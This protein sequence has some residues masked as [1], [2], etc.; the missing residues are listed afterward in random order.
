MNII[1]TIIWFIYFFGYLLVVYPVQL[2]GINALK[3]GD[4]KKSDALAKKYVNPWIRGLFKIANVKVEV[5]GKENIPTD[6]ACVIVC[7]HRGQ[8]DIAV[9][10]TEITPNPP[11]LLSKI[12]V[13]KIPF[14]RQWMRMLHCVFVDRKDVKKSVEALSE[15]A[16]VVKSGYNM[17]IFPEGTRYKGEAG[18]IGEFKAGAFKIAQKTGAPIVPIAMS[19]TRELMES[20]NMIMTPGTVKIN[21][22]P[23]IETKD[24]TKEEFKELPLKTQKLIQEN[25]LL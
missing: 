1:R 6:R 22:L 11:G 2:V 5:T 9:A 3:K 13:K 16:K 15:A 18:G 14:V 7:N 21:I 17:V 8:Y 24:L 23:L 4:Y 20:H 12:E 10:L 25:I 19:G